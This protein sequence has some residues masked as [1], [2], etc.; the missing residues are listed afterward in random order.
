MGV[1][2]L[3]SAHPMSAVSSIMS[4]YNSISTR[5]M[6]GYDSARLPSMLGVYVTMAMPD[7]KNFT[8][9]SG[10]YENSDLMHDL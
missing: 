8:G 1:L 3:A 10:N 9:S 4:N 6:G 2:G 7:D 5:I